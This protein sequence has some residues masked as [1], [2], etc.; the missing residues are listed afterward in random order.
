MRERYVLY[1]EYNKDVFDEICGAFEA[2]FPHFTKPKLFYH[3]LKGDYIQLYYCNKPESAPQSVWIYCNHNISLEADF[4]I[5]Q[6]VAKVKSTILQR[7]RIDDN[8]VCASPECTHGCYFIVNKTDNNYLIRKIA[9]CLLKYGCTVFSFYGKYANLW[10]TVF[11]EV[12]VRKYYTEDDD[13]VALTVTAENLEALADD[14]TLNIPRL[15]SF[16]NHCRV[17]YYDDETSLTPLQDLLF[18]NANEYLT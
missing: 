12:F 1:P 6:F 8:T 13:K 14:I 18:Q 15:E 16:E 7:I 5:F 2:E 9:D 3:F 11:D 4:D 10:H 17:L